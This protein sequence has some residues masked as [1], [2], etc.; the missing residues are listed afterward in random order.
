MRS[1]M[2]WT[3]VCRVHLTQ[4]REV[5]S[6]TEDWKVNQNELQSMSLFSSQMLYYT[7]RLGL[8]VRV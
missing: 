3:G 1:E 5:D 6:S 2:R 7:G 8:S 4:E